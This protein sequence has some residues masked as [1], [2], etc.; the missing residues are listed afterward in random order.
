M[1]TLSPRC[2]VWPIHYVDRGCSFT[3]TRTELKESTFHC[4]GVCLPSL[5]CFPVYGCVPSS[6]QRTDFLSST[7]YWTG[8]CS[9]LHSG[10][11]AEDCSGSLTECWLQSPPCIIDCVFLYNVAL[12]KIVVV[13]SYDSTLNCDCWMFLF[14]LTHR[15]RIFPSPLLSV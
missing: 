8:Y 9:I 12:P 15:L 4:L 14:P 6:T 10:S 2:I 7:H 11:W 3:F 13:F 1:L 5:T